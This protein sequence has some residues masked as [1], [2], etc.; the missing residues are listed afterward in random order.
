MLYLVIVVE[1][2]AKTELQMARISMLREMTLSLC[3]TICNL[4]VKSIVTPFC[5]ANIY[6]TQTATVNQ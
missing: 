5:D 1:L 3:N 4:P 6:F 2:L